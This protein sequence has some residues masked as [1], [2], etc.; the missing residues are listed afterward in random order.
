MN[1]RI[2]KC[3]VLTVCL[4]AGGLLMSG[5]ASAQEELQDDREVEE[6]R[7][8]TQAISENMHRRLSTVHD[9][10]GDDRLAEALEGL[11][12]LEKMKPNDYE[13]A[14]IYQTYGFVFVRQDQPEKAIDYFERSLALEA[15]P[16]EAQQGMLYSLAGLYAS[17]EMY[18]KAISTMREWFRYEPD[19]PADAYILIGSSFTQM[20]RYKEALPYV[21]KAIEKS[22]KPREDWYMLEVAIHFETNQFRD[23]VAAVKRIL[24]Y[25]PDKEKYWE[26][27]FAAYL[28][29]EQEKDALDVLMVAYAHGLMRNESKV[30]SLVQLA[31]A[32][33]MPFAAGKILERELEAGNVEA[34]KRHLDVLLQAWLAAREY[35]RAIAT[36]AKLGPLSDDGEYYMQRA[37]IHSELG[38]WRQAAEAANQ[39]LDA[40]LTNPAEAHIL[41]GMAYSEVEQFSDSLIAFRRA[42]EVGDDR[43]RKNADA[44]ISFVE[45]KIAVSRASVASSN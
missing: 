17:E 9:Q 23:A 15:L 30:L 27:L 2:R 29:L 1:D 35:D 22:T 10:L 39:A 25:W 31:M 3:R 45:E 8:R 37:G 14:L 21:K 33:D 42:K 36:I 44:W 34:T 11:S 4:L 24:Q 13:E 41:A 32:E 26:M 16:N 20:D 18:E 5:A 7:D 12:R 28:K 40:G 43:E 38:E 6:R 19:P